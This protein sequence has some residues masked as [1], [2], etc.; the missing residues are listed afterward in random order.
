MVERDPVSG[1]STDGRGQVLT[2]LGRRG[3]TGWLKQADSE[4]RQER[5]RR[6]YRQRGQGVSKADI[7]YR[8]E[9]ETRAQRK[10][11]FIREARE[12][13]VERREKRK[14]MYE[15]DPDER[16]KRHRVGG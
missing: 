11:R 5:N 13:I 6:K 2:F 14:K 7:E 1:S 16:T 4:Y 9:G 10:Q 15:P 12:A 3:Q 8:Q